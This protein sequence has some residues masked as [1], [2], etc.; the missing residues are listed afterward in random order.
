MALHDPI[1]HS[2]HSSRVVSSRHEHNGSELMLVAPR[3]QHLALAFGSSVGSGDL[4]NIRHAKPPQLANL[5]CAR[6]LVREATA[7]ELMIFSAWRIGKNRDARRDAAF[8]EVG[9][10]ERPG[11]GGIERY[12]DDVG[13]RDRLI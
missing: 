3:W 10:F 11:A 12:H 7:D 9:R 1:E 4:H 5:P 6:I 13:G 8:H 2:P